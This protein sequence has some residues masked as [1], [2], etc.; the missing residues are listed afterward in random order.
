[1]KYLIV[2]LGNIG[3]EYNDTRHNIGFRALDVFAKASN[4][5]FEGLRYGG[6]AETSLKG[7]KLILLKPNTF[8][9]LSGK[10]VRYWMQEEKIKPEN[11][12]IITDDLALPFETLR[13]KS[14]GGHGGHN[15]LTNIIECLG[16]DKFARLRVGI[17]DN[18]SRGKQIDYVLG[19]WTEKESEI[20]PFILNDV[21]D[22][23]T[24]FVNIGVDRAMN[25]VN[26][27]KKD[28]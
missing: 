12:L 18:F 4:A 17:G 21:A 27:N 20:L 14:K 2:G 10:A 13:L 3:N 19:K 1:M 11:L 8:M 6:V 7:K 26:T 25:I 24:S 22:A 9:N 28:E 23:I 15:G 16:Y 5:S